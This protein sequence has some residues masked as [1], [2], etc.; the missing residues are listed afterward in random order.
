MKR[1]ALLKELST[2]GCIL[3]R[4]AKKHDIYLNPQ[5]GLKAPLPRHTEVADSLCK[6]IRKQLGLID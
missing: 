5:N 3:V 4:H 2:A 1:L 6:I